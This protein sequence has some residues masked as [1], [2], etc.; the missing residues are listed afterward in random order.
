[1]HD[2]GHAQAVDRRHRGKF[3]FANH[4]IVFANRVRALPGLPIYL[5]AGAGAA[6]VMTTAGAF[7]TLE[8]PFLTRLTFWLMLIGVNVALWIVWFSWRVRKPADWWRAA[9]LGMIVIN[10]PMP[11]EITLIGRLLGLR[12]AIDWAST[13]ASTAAISIALLVVLMIAVRSPRKVEV[14]VYPK[15]KLWR[16]GFQDPAAI[17]AIAAEDHYCRIWNRNG[18]NI[19]VHARFSDLTDELKTVDG[20]VVRR[21][22]WVAAGF[23]SKI[24]RNGRR[25]QI[26]VIDGRSIVVSGSAA[27][28]LRARGWM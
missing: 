11:L 22:Q 26:R 8:L 24:E 2:A 17:A 5:V 14:P 20:A 6:L 10:A 13:W 15:G 25:W 4:A 23:V 1:M 9:L 19:L 7:G 16:A 18:T 27:G 12:M 21:G 3:A 28:E